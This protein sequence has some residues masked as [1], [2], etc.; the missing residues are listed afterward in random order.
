MLSLRCFC[1]SPPMRVSAGGRDTE[2]GQDRIAVFDGPGNDAAL[3]TPPPFSVRFSLRW[4]I[5]HPP[6]PATDA[7]ASRYRNS[8]SPF[9]FPFGF[10]STQSHLLS[11]FLLP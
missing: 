9:S 10:S 1:S 3:Q 2:R 4:I 8:T 7:R 5:T 11:M 6:L